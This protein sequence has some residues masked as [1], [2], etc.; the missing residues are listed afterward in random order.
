MIKVND[1]EIDGS[2]FR[3]RVSANIHPTQLG[4][5]VRILTGFSHPWGLT[6]NSQQQLVVAEC[7]PSGTEKI[8]VAEK[9]G[10]KVQ[11]ISHEHFMSPRGVAVGPDGAIFVTDHVKRTGYSC[12]SKFDKN[13]GLVK[14]IRGE[15][16][17]P[18]FL[19]IIE[20]VLYVCV[21]GEVKVFDTDLD[22][23][24]SIPT[25]ECPQPHD[26]ALGSEGLYV[27]SYSNPGKIGVYTQQGQFKHYLNVGIELSHP[28]GICIDSNGFIFVT[29][30]GCDEE[31]VY[32]F[33]PNG[34]LVVSFGLGVTGVL[35]N[36]A[37]IIIDEDGFV[38]VSD[39]FLSYIVVF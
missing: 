7:N 25:K 28:R 22:L 10:K 27:V 5:P 35:K 29:Q 39:F 34:N 19:K 15:L 20:N 32:V 38:Y 1:K 12:L 30:G 6:L 11:V 8:T 16:K 2:P 14:A 33:T 31:G 24:G 21:E 13:G 18:F 26:I 17:K 3:M 37:G 36:P 23:I 4:P 9:D